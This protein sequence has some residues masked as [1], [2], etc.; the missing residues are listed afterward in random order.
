[1]V[2]QVLFL[3]WLTN[4]ANPNF[5]SE[6]CHARKQQANVRSYRRHQQRFAQHKSPQALAG[7]T[8]NSQKRIF[9]PALKSFVGVKPLS[10]NKVTFSKMCLIFS[11][12]SYAS[13]NDKKHLTG[14]L[15][16]G[17]FFTSF[18]CTVFVRVRIWTFLVVFWCF[19]LH[20]LHLFPFFRVIN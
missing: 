6:K 18:L 19:V 7:I 2:I 3:I 14:F 10:L 16:I 8:H 20:F 11:F 13:F 12:I 4:I 17:I 5:K 9:T 1:M 15:R